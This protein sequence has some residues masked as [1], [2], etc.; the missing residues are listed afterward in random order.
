VSRSALRLLFLI[1]SMTGGAA[2]AAAPATLGYQGNLANAAGQPITGD[3]SITFRL[4]DVASGGSALWTEVQPTVEV[5][6][7]NLSVELGS[8]TPLPSTIW[9]RQLYLGVQIA[10]DSEMLPRP[11]LTATPYALRA[12]GTMRRTIVVSAEGTPAQNGAA[13]LAA[14]AGITD[15]SAASPVAVEIDAGTFD[16]G[17]ATL[18]MP[19]YSQIAGRGQNVSLITSAVSTEISGAT[20]QLQADSSARDLT[21]RNTGV[22]VGESSSAAGIAAHAPGSALALTSNVRLER[23]AGES[24][25]ASGSNGQRH[26]ITLCAINSRAQDIT[27]Y[28]SGGQFVS[29]LRADCQ[30]VGN[31]SIDGATVVAEA[32]QD[33]A[34]GAFLTAGPNTEWRR[35]RV[36]VDA[37]PTAGTVFGL[38]FVYPGSFSSTLNGRLSDSS[39][40]ITGT[41][42]FTATGTARVEGIELSDSAQL[43]LI[44]RVSV[45]LDNVRAASVTGV[46]LFEGTNNVGRT[47]QLNDVDVR[48]TALQD[49][50]LGFGEIS[51]LRAERLPPTLNRVRVSVDCVAG[52][53]NPCVGIAQPSNWAPFPGT[54]VVQ[55]SSISVGHAG[56]VSAAAPTQSAALQVAGPVRV[57]D[58]SLRVT[59]SA[60]AEPVS[61]IHHVAS[62]AVTEM[63]NSTV[64]VTDAANSNSLCLL[65]GTPGST[66]E[67]FGNHV[68]GARCDAG[69]IN[70]TCA[71]TT[72]RGTGFLASACP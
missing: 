32:G 65:A 14:V 54:L 62:T 40:T 45:H 66:G 64:V 47:V 52:G 10:G 19:A 7:G 37:Q 72:R 16:L 17:T 20:L 11:A 38:R 48:V 31:L 68:Q 61:G 55:D 23:V 25:A 5:D 13:L 34:R 2:L 53:T 6:G 59:R 21:A 24:V 44:E 12:A 56:P 29:A 49:P 67:W 50:A 60:V 22:P 36:L 42:P 58:S 57:L 69:G 8:V 51:G 46:R 63:A 3:L 71:G 18:L 28:A 70:L 33:G 30:G 41:G 26:G 39:V 4:F 43:A 35:L 9:G 15:A 1:C 27:A